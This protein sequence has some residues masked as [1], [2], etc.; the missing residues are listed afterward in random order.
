MSADKSAAALS[1]ATML[2]EQLM[3]KVQ[4]EEMPQEPQQ[5][6]EQPQDASQTPE[7]APGGEEMPEAEEPNVEEHL[8]S[9]EVRLDEKLELF[10]EEVLEAISKSNGQ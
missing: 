2:S 3:P 5:T 8:T 9:M 4:P 6:P 7:T 10:K 1:F